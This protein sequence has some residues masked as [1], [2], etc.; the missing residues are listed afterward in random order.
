MLKEKHEEEGA[1][2]WMVTFGDLMSQLL[3]FF[4]LLV[5]FSVFD[6]IKFSTVSGAL[7]YS[8]GLLSGW[9][10]TPVKVKDMIIR[11]REYNTEEEKMAGI[12]YR[13]KKFAGRIGASNALG[14]RIRREGLAIVLRSTGKISM[15]DSGSAEI[16]PEFLPIL[17]KIAEELLQ[18]PNE[19]RIE[20]H[21]DNRPI[22]T[23]RY[24]SN[25][26]LS[27]ARAAS[28]ARY[29]IRKGIDPKR[30]SIVGYGELKPLTSNDTPEGRARNRRVEILVLKGKSHFSGTIYPDI[31]LNQ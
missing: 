25:W 12:G 28:V 2:E 6:E 23:P 11:P 13:L 24:P 17:D 21:T 19:I 20:G 7:K 31:D 29:L 5:S 8:F 18:I 14:A 1:P 15:F 10:E 22:N 4:V 16:K 3:T 27:T 26:E 9:R 30:I